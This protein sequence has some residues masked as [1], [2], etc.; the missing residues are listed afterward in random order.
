MCM[1]LLSSRTAVF[2]GDTPLGVR[3]ILSFATGGNLELSSIETTKE[4]LQQ[5]API[6]SQLDQL[7][8][9]AGGMRPTFAG[10]ER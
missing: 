6:M 9:E 3:R 8:R 2:P 5:T 7:S 4:I 1:P 10:G